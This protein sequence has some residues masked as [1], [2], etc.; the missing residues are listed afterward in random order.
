MRLHRLRIESF[1][2]IGNV[3]VEFGPGLNVLYGPNDLGKSTVVA[4]IRLGLLLPHTSTHC[5]QYVGWT[6]SDD[7]IVEMTFETEAQRIWRVRKQFGKNGSSLLQE[8]RNGQDF[9]DV[10]RGR[11]VDAKLREILRWGIPEPGG[12]GGGKGLPTSFL[13]TAL[14]SPQEDV[15]AVLRNSLQD[16]PIGSGKEQIAAALQAVAQDAL[17]VALLRETQA[18]RDAA[19]TDKGAKKTAKGSVFKLVAERLNETRDEKEKLQRIVA[20]SESVERQL[21]DLTDRRAH[22]QESLAVATDLVANLERLASQAACHSVAAEQVR[23]TQED[24]L[25]IQRIGTEVDAAE[26]EVVELVGKIGKAEQALNVARGRQVEADAALESAEEAAR[27]E[28]S[29]PGMIDTVVR[30]QLEFRKSAADQAVREAQQRIDAALAA[31]KLVEAVAAAERELQVQQAKADSALESASKAIATAKTDDDELQRCDLL[32]RALDVHAADKQAKVAQAA[33]DN[34]AAL[35]TR[36]EAA[37]GERAVLAGQRS[38]ITV[39]IP[40]ALGPMRK[41]AR[42]LA[43]ARGA[44]DVGFVVTVNPKSRLDLW[45]RKDGQEVDSTSI[46]QPLDIEANAE[47]EVSI[48]DIATVRVRGGRREAQEKAQ[49][50]EDRWSGEVGPHLIAAGVTDL[51]GLDVKIAEA[52]ELDTDIKKKDAEMESLRAQIAALT[53]AAETLR[54]ASDRAAACRASLGDVGLDT[55]A[56]DIKALGADVTAGLRKRR[57]QL[58]KQAE[59]ARGIAN[60]AANDRTLAAERTRHSRLALDAASAARDAALTA[61]PQG[62]D[63]ALVAAQAALAAAIALKESLTAEFA[64][65]EHTIDERKNRIDVALS[66]ARTNVA[67]A[68][69]AVETAQ[70][71]LTTAKT[72]HAS[73]HG[74]LI[75][76]RK[77]RAAEN[78]AAAEARLH[79]ATERH[80]AL[81]IPDRIVT[82]DEASAGR[83][84]AAGIKLDLERIERDIQRAHGA[85]E[86]LGGAVARERLRDAT[87]AFEL[88]EHQEREIEAEYEAWKLLLDQM[89][90]ADAAQ[91]S[92]L[93]QALVP[94]I[95]GRFQEL[96]QRRYETVHLTAQLATEGIVVLG[97]L[98]PATQISVGTREQLSTLYRLSLA[99]YLRTVIV[100]DDQLV[101][102]DD[103]RMDW[104]RA[105]LTE[106]AHSFQIV[107][108]TCRPGDYLL[109]SALVP[110]GSAVHADTDGGFIRAVDLGRALCRR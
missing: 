86:Q 42:E 24:V 52:Q 33:V 62:V 91:A 8:S 96:T 110:Q 56:A 47:I 97:A 32:E 16:D 108:F 45:V 94:A 95:A 26:R 19:Y 41:L 48:A 61:F 63:A 3:D 109:S 60:Q 36:L 55:L 39:P 43:A 102:S 54:E 104:F 70:G 11:K 72:N 7:P 88:A 6:G 35:R 67:Q 58:S 59:A 15:S 23:L 21:R 90:E 87:E 75:E 4:G 76:L 105:L 27:A 84:I 74:R 81:P 57:Q 51:D 66:G 106:K 79:E 1:G 17:F 25:R 31:Q 73:E 69:I 77:Q 65:L 85:L 83:T 40:G 50:L 29:D 20:E 18:R 34:E 78:L 89:K 100:L 53:G 98:R 30:Q 80:A 38:A 49:G 107:V 93:G 101:Q 37:S 71:R 103:N 5:D 64:S 22:K 2:A 13:A 44:L 82:D 46:A 68:T 92:N 9:D 10:E 99:E 28:G 12:T 14:L